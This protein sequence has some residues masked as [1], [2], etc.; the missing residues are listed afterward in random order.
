MIEGIGTLRHTV[1]AGDP[2]P[3]DLT[4]AELPAVDNN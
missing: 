1:A 2:P 4:G 3:A